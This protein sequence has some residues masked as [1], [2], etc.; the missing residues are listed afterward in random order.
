MQLASNFVDIEPVGSVVCLCR[1]DK[2]KKEIPCPQIVLYIY[3][4]TYLQLN[5]YDEYMNIYLQLKIKKTTTKKNIHQA[6]R[7]LRMPGT[8]LK[9]I[10]F[11]NI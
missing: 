4:Y 5:I 3:S 9:I 11:N 7:N 10:K 1:K 8:N 6:S 2:A